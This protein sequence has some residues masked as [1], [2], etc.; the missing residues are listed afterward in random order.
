M[1]TIMAHWH[2]PVDYSI[3][4]KVLQMRAESVQEDIRRQNQQRGDK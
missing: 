1:Q 2:V 3:E 4:F